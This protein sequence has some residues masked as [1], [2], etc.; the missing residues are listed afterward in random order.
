MLVPIG[1]EITSNDSY[2]KLDLDYITLYNLERLESSSVKSTYDAAYALLHGHT[3]SHQNAFFNMI[4][5]AING[6]NA[7]R[8]TETLKLLNQ[9]LLRPTRDFYD[10]VSSQVAVCGTKSCN[11][12]P[13]AKPPQTDFLWQRDPFQL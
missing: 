9:W 6:P 10:D 13:D 12:V 8:D 2:F 4:D 11:P 7:T 3:A 1:L 5:R